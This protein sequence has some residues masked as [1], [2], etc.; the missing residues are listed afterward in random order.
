M[1]VFTIA[2]HSRNLIEQQTMNSAAE[3]QRLLEQSRERN[4]RLGIT[5]ALL[6]NEG[7]FVQILEGDEPAVR[8]V[9]DVIMRDPRHTDIDVLPARYARERTFAHWSMAFVGAS[10][11]AK[12]YYRDFSLSDKLEWTSNTTDLLA[13]LILDLIMV[14]GA[15]VRTGASAQQRAQ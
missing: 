10:P 4:T 2:Y 8:E 13:A 5:G 15:V 3:I 1:S 14:Q 12:D 7:R 9:M 6:F 11:Q